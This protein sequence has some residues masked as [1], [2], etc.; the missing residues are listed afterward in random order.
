MLAEFEAANLAGDMKTARGGLSSQPPNDA[1]INW[2][3]RGSSGDNFAT[4]FGANAET[5]REVVDAVIRHYERVITSFN[6]FND[7]NVINVAI[8]MEGSGT[9]HGGGREVIRRTSPANQ[10][11]VRSRSIEVTTSTATAVVRRRI[12]HR[13]DAG[14]LLR[15][16]RRLRQRVRR[17]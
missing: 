10:S 11:A 13:P 1:I 17:R 14:R 7:S 3:N 12:L 8:S 9:G 6:H 4:T 2:S 16:Q 5:A 15:V